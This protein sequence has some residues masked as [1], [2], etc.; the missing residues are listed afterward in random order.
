MEGQELNKNLSTKGFT[1]IELLIAMVIIII[2]MFGLLYGILEYNKYNIRARTKDK[3]TEVAK[4]FTAYIESIPYVEDER[5]QSILYANNT[6]WQNITC[7]N[8]SCSIIEDENFYKTD[9]L[10]L[11]PNIEQGNN[12]QCRGANCPTNLPMCIYEGFVGKKI[13]AGI[14]VARIVKDSNE[15]GKIVSVIVWYTEPFTNKQ[16][17]IST[18]VIKEKK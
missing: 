15:V 6:S 13:F 9:N 8:L 17:S 2:V 1:L 12:C 7:N 11:Y 10:R 16:K 5:G 4:S 3:A 18:I 14:N